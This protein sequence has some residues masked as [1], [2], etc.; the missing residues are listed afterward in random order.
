MGKAR[1]GVEILFLLIFLL[2]LTSG[3]MIIWLAIFVVGLLTSALF[4]RYFCGYICPM[5]TFM[6]VSEKIAKRMNSQTS[7]VPK[8]LQSRW[9]PWF[10]LALMISTMVFSRQVL[11]RE[12]PVLLILLPLSFIMTLRLKPSVFH[13]YVC[14]Y[15]VLL[16][17]TGMYAKFAFSAD[18]TR[19]VNCKK[20]VKV[21]PA[22]AITYSPVTK[23]VK[24]N[25]T[26]CHQ[27]AKCIEECPVDV[28]NYQ[29]IKH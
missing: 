24:V 10:V 9:M 1:I 16:K 6:R 11:Q 20:C 2:S 25:A 21:C 14:P 26:L 13:N 17:L 18:E 15:G 12:F 3:K 22:D 8:W 27:C 19:C 23:V 5:N 7:I 28:I 29:N 4:G